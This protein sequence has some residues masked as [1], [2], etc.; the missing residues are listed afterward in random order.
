M[1]EA[2]E[3]A[4]DAE[5][6]RLRRGG[7]TAPAT[8]IAL[9]VADVI[10]QRIEE[11]LDRARLELRNRNFSSVLTE[12]ARLGTS[13]EWL[14]LFPTDAEKKGLTEE[15]VRRHWDFLQRKSR[16]TNL[17]VPEMDQAFGAMVNGMDLDKNLEGGWGMY[18]Y[19][20]LGT[21]HSSDMM[22]YAMRVF[23]DLAQSYSQA[24]QV[25]IY[26]TSDM[27][28]MNPEQKDNFFGFMFNSRRA[29]QSL[30][31]LDTTH[32]LAEFFVTL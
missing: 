17:T 11:D 25:L 6:E 21:V 31:V 24:S 29:G 9:Y 14:R 16:E 32:L 15:D 20:Y 5:T 27:A 28:N 22:P 13:W 10:V 4:I 26:A 1:Q 23:D 7:D 18:K 30:D 19:F 8:E 2:F 3:R 12:Y